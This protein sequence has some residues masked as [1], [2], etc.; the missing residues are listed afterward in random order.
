MHST[1]NE[2]ITLHINGRSISVPAGT[3]VAAAVAMRGSPVTRLSVSGMPRAPLC[4][5]GICH[6]CRVTIDGQAH[7]LACQTLCSNGMQVRTAEMPA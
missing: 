3:S 5:M 7:R 6:E 4:G 2:V 1:T